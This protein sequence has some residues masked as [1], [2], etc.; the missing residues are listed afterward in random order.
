MQKII[1]T[2]T[3]GGL[4]L[5]ATGTGKTFLAG[6]VFYGHKISCLFIVDQLSLLYQTQTELESVLKESV[7]IVGE[8]KYDVQRVTIATVQTLALHRSD[9]NFKK[10]F[11]SIDLVIIDEIH[12]QMAKRDFK[13]VESIKPK[14]VYGLTATLQIKK[15]AVR[16]RAFAITGPVLYE[17]PLEQGIEEKHLAPICAVLIQNQKLSG[18]KSSYQEDY[19][20]WISHNKPRNQIIED[21]VRLILKKDKANTLVFVD[22]IKHLKIL[23]KRLRDTPYALVYGKK[24]ARD[25]KLTISAF[26]QNKIKVI[27]TNRVFEKGINILSVQNGINGTGYKDKNK[28]VQFAGRLV[29]KHAKKQFAVCWDIYDLGNRFEKNSKSRLRAY[30]EAKIPILKVTFPE[31]GSFADQVVWYDEIL[32]KIERKLGVSRHFF[33]SYAIKKTGAARETPVLPNQSN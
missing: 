17:Y 6:L 3:T 5:S 24:K 28:A 26:E 33:N 12:T 10:W 15:R 1:E 7:G 13:V 4:I 27:L 30:K 11:E 22:R 8:S 20:Q 16:V 32:Q 25:R 29:R 2:S 31:N 14:A 21:L 23:A 18:Y 19:K 9:A